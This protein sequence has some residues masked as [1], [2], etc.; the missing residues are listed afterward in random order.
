MAK[1]KAGVLRGLNH[2]WR[3]VHNVGGRG[4]VVAP[5][6]SKVAAVIAVLAVTACGSV[7]S[8]GPASS[9]RS[10]PSATAAVGQS[11]ESTI[12]PNSGQIAG[13]VG[14]PAG[15][16]PAET[17]YALAT[18][19]SR[20]FTVETAF[21]QSTYTMLGVAAGDYFVLAVAP[22]SYYLPISAISAA[23]G[24]GSV[25]RFPAGF[26]KSVQCGL[27]IGCDDHSLISIHVAS[28]TTT[29]GVAP[30]DWY[31]PIGTFPIIPP[32]GAAPLRQGVPDVPTGSL[33]GFFPDSVVTFELELMAASATT[34]RYVA[35]K[36][37]CPVNIAC[38]WTVGRHDGSS[39][40][41]YTLQA[42]SNETT[43]TCAIYIISTS[44]GWEFLSGSASGVVCSSNGEPF[45]SVGQSGQIQ[46]ALGEKGCVNVHSTPSLSAKVVAC[47][48]AG[49][50]I[51]VDDGP[52]YVPATPPL[53]QTDLP[54]AL[55]YWWHIAGRGWVVHAYVLTRHYG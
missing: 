40:A 11:P 15:I 41:Y 46:M 26:T 45:P 19:N 32:S 43:Q 7:A 36:T 37:D 53:P 47:L 9:A 4:S 44:T 50:A 16:L 25:Y 29:S 17:V 28:G 10:S 33:A 34:S 30:I 39:A 51:S 3:R 55:D 54:W 13:N 22:A 12:P 6:M 14:Y 24:G 49:T 35:S 8:R 21:G 38:V 20:F 1:R 5:T 52:A 42:G 23:R 27:S 18:D 48:P 31:A 2:P